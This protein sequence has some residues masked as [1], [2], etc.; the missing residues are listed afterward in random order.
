MIKFCLVFTLVFLAHSA[1][2]QIP[3]KKSNTFYFTIEKLGKKIPYQKFSTNRFQSNDSTVYDLRYK[4]LRQ[5]LF[6]VAYKKNEF[7]SGSYA[8][9]IISFKYKVTFLRRD[10][11][12]QKYTDTNEEYYDIQKVFRAE[13]I[14]KDSIPYSVE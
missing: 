12:L 7:E 1:L 2:A 5:R 14:P 9:P 10:T 3:Y 8:Q 11:V 4:K 13:L 6:A